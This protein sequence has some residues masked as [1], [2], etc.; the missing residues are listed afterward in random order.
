[1]LLESK[2]VELA[3]SRAGLET[4]GGL[5]SAKTDGASSTDGSPFHLA[6]AE[7]SGNSVL[8]RSIATI[9]ARSLL[10]RLDGMVSDED[11]LKLRAGHRAVLTAVRAGEAADAAAAMRAHL[12]AARDLAVAVARRLGQD[13]G[14]WTGEGGGPA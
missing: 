9:N 4:D 5:A 10:L 13:A 11:R 14:G 8:A 1:M 2:A 12:G 3:A 7:A 6:M